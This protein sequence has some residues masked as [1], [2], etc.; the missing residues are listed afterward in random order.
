MVACSVVDT[1]IGIS[2][3]DL[4][5]VFERLYRV[6]SSRSRATGGSGIGLAITRA[7]VEAHGGKIS[8]ASVPGRGSEFTIRLPLAEGG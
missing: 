7:I 5:R 4:P 3:E 1:G 6:E 8:A 2:A